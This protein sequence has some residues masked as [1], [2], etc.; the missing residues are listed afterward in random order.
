MRE[1]CA[2]DISLS[3]FH[4]RV[5]LLVERVNGRMKRDPEAPFPKEEKQGSMMLKH[6]MKCG[7]QVLRIVA[8]LNHLGALKLAT[9]RKIKT[10]V[11][12]DYELI[13]L[14]L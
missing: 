14:S 3:Q 9:P 8:D 11:A 10:K 6:R 13:I 7:L 1:R 12:V 2:G 5:D 4:L